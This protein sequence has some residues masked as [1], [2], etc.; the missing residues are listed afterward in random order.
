MENVKSYT[1]LFKLL[2]ARLKNPKGLTTEQK[3]E[4]ASRSWEI[5][6]KASQESFYI[7]VQLMAPEF[8]PGGHF[9]SGKHIELICKKLQEV[10]EATEQNEYYVQ[11][12]DAEKAEPK[13]QQLWVAPRS[14]KSMISSVLFPLWCMGRNPHWYILAIGHGQDFAE[15]TFGARSLELVQSQTYATIFPNTQIN[16]KTA[17]RGTWKTTEGGEF[18]C[19]GAG[20]RIA[21]KGAHILIND[22]VMVDHTAL[23]KTER[24]KINNWYIPSAR[25][26]L[27]PGGG[28]VMINARWH[29]DD[30]SGFITRE[31]EERGEP[32]DIIRIPAILDKESAELL[33]LPEGGSYWPERISMKKL[34]SDKASY[35]NQPHLWSALYMQDPISEG[36]SFVS[37][38]DFR[39]WTDNDFPPIEYIAVSID[40]ALSQKE[41]ADFTAATVW[42]MFTTYGETYDGY[43]VAV[44]NFILLYAK[45]GKYDFHGLCTLCETLRLEFRPD[46]FI[47]ENKASGIQLIDELRRRGFFVQGFTPK[48][49]QDKQTRF[50]AAAPMAKEGR[51]WVPDQNGPNTFENLPDFLEECIRF[52]YAKNDDFPDTFSQFV[53]W[54]KAN[55]LLVSEHHTSFADDQWDEDDTQISKGRSYWSSLA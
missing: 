5:A 42:G 16:K 31:D 27:M 33:D 6:I 46:I 51:I 22:D 18:N 20:A 11:N 12:G 39:V 17:S 24:L 49:G 23:S 14:G 3:K 21:G 45:R 54:A 38:E 55:S 36:G 15:A 4:L 10:C 13:R 48:G 52:P 40:S 43:E 26:R 7:F 8:I 37:L 30:L 28:E 41:S 47:V 34:M 35:A 50:L 25:S 2:Q 9:Q 29:L 1:E 44:K 19:A 32:W 53:L